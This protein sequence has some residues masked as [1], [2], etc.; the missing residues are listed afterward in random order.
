M[1]DVLAAV[2]F[3]M[4]GTL[5]DSEKVWDVSLL[6]LADHLGGELT[7]QL[8]AS[9]VGSSLPATIAT[10]HAAFGVADS[11][12][13]ATSAAYLLDETAVLFREE[14]EW[15][16]G[17]KELLTE[18]D[19]AGVPM[20]LVTATVRRLTDLIL[21][22]IGR[23]W[24]TAT[25]CGD[26]VEHQKPA[27]DP[28]RRAAELLGANPLHCAAIE[29]S[30]NGTRSAMAAGCATLT[31]PCDAPVPDGP[32]RHFATSLTEVDRASLERL[33]DAHLAARG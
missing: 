10:L 9:L 33:V 32:G 4:D 24:F 3:D 30:E 22:A 27:P 1:D 28:Y 23:H 8:R 6:R 13:P 20:A 12:D 17:A 11:V 5:V 25:V 18:L 2:L 29:D 26:E 31:V 19:A 14:I 7:P 21:D 16:P 15:R